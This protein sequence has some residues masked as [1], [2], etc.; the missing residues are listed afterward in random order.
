MKSWQQITDDVAVL[1]YP[2]RAFGIDFGRNVTLLRLRDGRLVIHS[3]ARFT[4]EDVA[5]IRRFGEPAWLLDATRM[6]DTFAREARLALP[7]IPY[8]AP[9]A[10]KGVPTIPLLPPPFDWKGEIEVLKIDGLRKIDEHAF[11]HRASR[12]LLLADLLFH[13]PPQTRGWPRFFVRHVMRLPRL[14]GISAFFRL[15]IRDREAFRRSM[16]SVLGCDFDRVIV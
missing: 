1:Q 10:L 2:L 9:D 8:L 4:P 12:T 16:A 14:I 13:F 7:A 3:T 5:A 15:M 6:H 11:F